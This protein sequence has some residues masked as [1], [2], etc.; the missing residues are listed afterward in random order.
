MSVH[1]I[2]YSI[3]NHRRG[4]I[5]GLVSILYFLLFIKARISADTVGDKTGVTKL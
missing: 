5:V 2:Q 3:Y 4:V 1:E